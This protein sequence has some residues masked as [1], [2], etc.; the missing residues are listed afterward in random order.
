MIRENQRVPVRLDERTT[1]L[2]SPA[3]DREKV[4]QLYTQFGD[5]QEKRIK[6]MPNKAILIDPEVLI[7]EL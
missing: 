3:H 1:I 6:R 4:L 7:S 2:M 5:S